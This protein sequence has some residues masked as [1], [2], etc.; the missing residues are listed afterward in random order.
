MSK[1]PGWQE[2][3][4]ELIKEAITEL[5]S[6]DFAAAYEAGELGDNTKELQCMFERIK[7]ES[8]DIAEFM[9]LLKEDR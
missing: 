3:L 5:V 2:D 6:D 4:A 8:E 1:Y 9:E 7:T